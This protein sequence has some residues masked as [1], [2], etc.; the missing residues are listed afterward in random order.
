MALATLERARFEQAF[1]VHVD[2]DTELI[3]GLEEQL[4]LPAFGAQ[5]QPV[6]NYFNFAETQFANDQPTV[7]VVENGRR[8]ES[9]IYGRSLSTIHKLGTFM[10]R[11]LSIEEVINSP[12]A[13]QAKIEFFTSVREG[14]GTD[15]E[16]GGGLEVREFDVRPIINGRVMSKDL[17]TAISDMT[18]SGLKCAEQ[19]VKND[20]RFEPQLTRSVWD[21]ENALL[22]DAMARG[23]TNYNMRIVVSPFPQEAAAQSGDE[24]WQDICYV[25]SLRRGFVQLYVMADG[26]LLTGSLSFDGSDKHKLRAIFDELGVDVPVDEITDNWLKYAITGTLSG[27]RAKALATAIANKA[28]DTSLKKNTNT[29]DVTKNYGV[30]M[31]RAF[32]E[33]YI[34]ICES[35][36]KGRQTQGVKDLILQF[37]NNAHNFNERY[38][39]ALY[40]M[41]AAVNEFVDDDAVVLHELLVYSTIEMM[42]ALHLQEQNLQESGEGDIHLLAA[43]LESADAASF[44]N[45][46]G[47]FGAD[48]ARNGRTYSACGLK[49]NLGAD[50]AIDENDPQL[51]LE[52]LL[53]DP[54]HV[55]GGQDKARRAGEDERGP[56]KFKCKYGH[57]N[58]RKPG[59]PLIT[60]CR[61]K[62]CPDP[63]WSVGCGL[64]GRAQKKDEKQFP[65]WYQTAERLEAQKTKPRPKVEAKVGKSALA[66]TA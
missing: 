66:L 5:V 23:E 47:G 57:D 10:M 7:E 14:F 61:D 28:G 51:Q 34:H 2:D 60:K 45:M 22:V 36:A 50:R 33:S 15:M 54:Q 46:M 48:G 19:T 20:P 17:K 59:G 55:F 32:N 40:R 31:E 16:L 43:V 3:L 58:E 27:E 13:A 9:E 29:V 62:S 44:Q 30:I 8:A 52:K 42:R 49:I 4:R 65:T 53:N 25:P 41:R 35:L 6:E 64:E 1:M 11:A 39:K 26:E 37:A 18:E 21:H 56:L 24:F 38:T 63:R 12:E